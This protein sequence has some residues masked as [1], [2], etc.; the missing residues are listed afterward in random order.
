VQAYRKNDRDTARKYMR[1][2]LLEDPSNVPAWLWMSA[3]VDDTQQQRECLERALTLDPNSEPAIRGLKILRLRETAEAVSKKH[4]EEQAVA[5]PQPTQEQP[6]A[7]EMDMAAQRHAGRLGE[8]LV[9]QGLITRKQLEMALDEQRLFWKKS[10]GVRAPLGNILINNGILTPQMLA[11]ALV[12]QQH[13]KL[14][15]RD[16][17]SPQYI[18][19]Y[20]VSS[21]LVSEQQLES[22]LAEQLRLRQKGTTMLLG[23][24]LIHAGYI[25]REVL[26]NILEH[27][28]DELFSRFGFED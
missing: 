12:A 19:E 25:T 5:S 9:E 11:T 16:K 17:Q 3:L 20:L 13:D 4:E 23:E 27:Q 2:V 14:H 28:R 24:L 8:Y 6:S 7:H 26:E 10:Q 21:G 15:G 18:G 22:V 1:Q